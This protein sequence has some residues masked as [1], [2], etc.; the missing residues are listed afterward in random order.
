VDGPGERRSGPPPGQRRP[1]GPIERYDPN[2]PRPERADR[3]ARYGS[4]GLSAS[5]FA[6]PVT[7]SWD[8]AAGTETAR[9]PKP[10]SDKPRP[11]KP[12]KAPPNKDKGKPKWAGKPAE[13]APKAARKHKDHKPRRAPQV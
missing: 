10:G 7:G 4:A 9:P 2:A 5:D 11:P 12:A 1:P 8:P 13:G 3:K 6:E